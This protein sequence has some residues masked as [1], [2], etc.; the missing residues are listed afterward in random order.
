MV[1]DALDLKVKNG[2]M[3]ARQ[4]GHVLEGRVRLVHSLNAALVIEG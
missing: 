3:D 1:L 4:R 2:W